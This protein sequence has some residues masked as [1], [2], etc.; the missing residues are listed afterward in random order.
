MTGMAIIQSEL[1]RECRLL[2]EDVARALQSRSQW[3]ARARAAEKELAEAL[4]ESDVLRAEA[5]V[6]RKELGA[7]LGDDGRADRELARL[8]EEN[9]KLRSAPATPSEDQRMLAEAL[10]GLAFELDRMLTGG[11]RLTKAELLR[12]RK[13]IPLERQS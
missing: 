13:M 9:E 8:R 7:A 4:H 2:S 1:R 5:S 10:K 11:A 3:R 6:L 12:V